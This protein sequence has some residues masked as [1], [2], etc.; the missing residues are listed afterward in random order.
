MT[1]ILA[2]ENVRGDFPSSSGSSPSRFTFTPTVRRVCFSQLSR[3]VNL[4]EIAEKTE[5]YSGS[6]LREL[7]RDAA[8]YRVR[9]YVREEQLRQVTEQLLDWDGEKNT[10]VRWFQSPALIGPCDTV[11]KLLFSLLHVCSQFQTCRRRTVAAGHPTGPSL[12]PGQNG[13]V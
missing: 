1:L 11:V 5:G 8:L 13:G 9:D 12:R 10:Y 3:S 7:C 2:G 6:D 4:T